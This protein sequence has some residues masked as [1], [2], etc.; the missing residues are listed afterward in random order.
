MK[1]DQDMVKSL[2]E[3][4]RME[5]RPEETATFVDQLPAIVDYVGTLEQVTVEAPPPGRLTPPSPRADEIRRS[6]QRDAILDQAPDRLDDFWRVP[7][8]M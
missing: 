4:A 5:L 8:V 1:I 7:P 6:T 3:L 2:G